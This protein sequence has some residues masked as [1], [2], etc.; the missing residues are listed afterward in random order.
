LSALQELG[1]LNFLNILNFLNSYHH[2]SNLELELTLSLHLSTSTRQNLLTFP[3][4]TF[5]FHLHLNWQ[6]DLVLGTRFARRVRFPMGREPPQ[7]A[8]TATLSH[9]V[10]RSLGEGGWQ[11]SPRIFRIEFSFL[12]SSSESAENALSVL[13][14]DFYL[15]PH[16]A[17][18]NLLFCRD[19]A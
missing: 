17:M 7:G 5:T 12:F 18:S 6:L 2:F 11:H 15:K 16:S 8:V 19:I 3:L 1:V 10:H 14:P 4:F 9:P 13:M